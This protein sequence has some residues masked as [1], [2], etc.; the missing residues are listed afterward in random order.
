MR[1]LN[2]RSVEVLAAVQTFGT[3]AWG[4]LIPVIE[5]SDSASAVNTGETIMAT[6]GII[7]TGITMLGMFLLAIT[8]LPMDDAMAPKASPQ[9]PTGG[10]SALQNAAKPAKRIAGL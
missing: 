7:I 10:T 4:L 5:T 2:V 1:L 3:T 6:W 9:P 8:S